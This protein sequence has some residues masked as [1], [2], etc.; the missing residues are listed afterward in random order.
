MKKLFFSAFVC[1]LAFV[2]HAQEFSNSATSTDFQKEQ[3]AIYPG[4]E[5]KKTAVAQQKCFGEKFNKFLNQHFNNEL[6]GKLELK[7]RL[8][9]Y[10]FFK[11]NKDGVIE[12]VRT[13]T[14]HPELDQEIKRV[15]ESFPK[16]K[17]ASQ[18]GKPI[19]IMCTIPFIFTV[20]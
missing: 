12:N 10:I 1:L 8:T 18:K 3:Y 4:C 16:V 2:G 6:P 5:S 14:P 19:S 17:P 11:I 13:R 20:V 9:M 7:G 15:L